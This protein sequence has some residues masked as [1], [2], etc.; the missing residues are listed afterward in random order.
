M[1]TGTFDVIQDFGDGGALVRGEFEGKGA[2]KFTDVFAFGLDGAAGAAVAPFAAAFEYAELQQEK[3][4]EGEALD[5]GGGGFGRVGEM[6]VPQGGADADETGG[7]ADFLGEE[8]DDEA[9]AILDDFAGP[10]AQQLLGK[11]AGGRVDRH[12][13]PGMQG[14]IQVELEI[15]GAELGSVAAPLGAAEKGH[16]AP[17][18]EGFLQVGL[19]E[20]DGPHGVAAVGEDG[21]GEVETT[22]R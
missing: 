19:I 1:A 12:L 5:G 7:G 13:A 20:P 15:G 9:G 4:V 2:G 17:A 10:E 16:V 11:L 18:L 14:T 22:G 6:D 3:L 21:P 8:L